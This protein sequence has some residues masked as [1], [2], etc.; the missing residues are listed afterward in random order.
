MSRD[1]V[2]IGFFVALLLGVAAL[3]GLVFVPYIPAIFF[4]I[5]LAVVFYPLHQKIL[6]A[7]GDRAW[8]ASLMSTLVVLIVIIIPLVIFGILLIQEATRLLS[9]TTS[10][11]FDVGATLTAVV[12]WTAAASPYLAGQLEVYVSGFDPQQYIVQGISW[13]LESA[14]AFIGQA[15]RLIIAGAISLLAVFYLFRDG[16]RAVR[17]LVR[18]SPLASG[19]ERM[20][21]S[22]ITDAVNSVVLGRILV[23]I[24]QGVLTAVALSVVGVPAAILWG[25]VAAILS[26]VPMLGP[27]L[28]IT[29]AA[30]YLIAIGSIG[31]GVGLLV[32]AFLAIYFVDDVLGPIFIER[33]IK[34]HPFLI[35]VSILGGISFFGPIGFV[36]GPVLLALLSVLLDMYPMVLE[37]ELSAKHLDL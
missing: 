2:Q 12:D 1:V 29:P 20:I 22:R 33:G 13:V 28:V 27:G 21:L 7:T 23:G 10:S 15:F 3:T 32:W 25:T 18:V 6:A 24:I 16:D 30:L 26:V 14:N 19:Y 34:I 36:A 37:R 5:V 35:L 11:Q 31:S 4:A 17:Y 9:L 8:I